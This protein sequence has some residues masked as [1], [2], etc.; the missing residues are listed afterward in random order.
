M[1]SDKKFENDKKKKSMVST[2]K[3]EKEQSVYRR[4]IKKNKNEQTV[5]CQEREGNILRHK[6]YLEK[7]HS[8]FY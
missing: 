4:K 7:K 5:W 8:K 3:I 6:E 1:N 2:K